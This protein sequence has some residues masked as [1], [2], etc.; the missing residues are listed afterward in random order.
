MKICVQKVRRSVQSNNP[1]EK[2]DRICL[3][4]L[5]SSRT[6]TEGGSILIGKKSL[7]IDAGKFTPA[8]KSTTHSLFVDVLKSWPSEKVHFP[9]ISN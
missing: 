3:K 9:D 7:P 1:L 8:V 4:Q 5:W 2:F 6:L